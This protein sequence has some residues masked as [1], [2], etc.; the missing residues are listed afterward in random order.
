MPKISWLP[1]IRVVEEYSNKELTVNRQSTSLAAYLRGP[2]RSIILGLAAILLV[3]HQ[4]FAATLPSGFSETRIAAGLTDPTAMAFAPDGRLFVCLQ[5]GQLRLIKDGA[6]LDQPFLTVTVDATGERGLLGVAFDPG[7]A[8]NNFIY[9]YYTVAST[10]RHNRVSRFTAAGDTTVPGSETVILELE[11]LSTATNHNGG[12]LHF[13]PDDRLYVAVGENADGQNAQTLSNRLGKL[14][15][16]NADGTIPSDN[17]FFNQA[18]GDNR[19]IWALG[20][21]NPFTF[22]FQSGTG[23]LFINDVGANAWEEINDGNAGAN[24]GWPD[25]EGPTTDTRYLSPI[26]AYQTGSGQ[27]PACAISGGTFYNPPLDQFPMEFIGQYFFADFC[28]GWIRQLDPANPATAPFFA[29]D[30]ALPVDLQVG[31]DG[32]LYYLARG[33]GGAVFQ[34]QFTGRDPTSLQFSAAAY[35]VSENAG[36]ATITVTRDGSASGAVAVDFATSDGSAVAGSDYTPTSGTLS[37]ADGD[38]T[39]KNFTV[40]ITN[41]N[42]AEPEE[43]VNLALSNPTG[44]A[45]LGPPSSSATLNIVNED[46]GMTSGGGGCVLNTDATPGSMLPALVFSAFYFLRRKRKAG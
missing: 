12:A 1:R 25:T 11:D 32:S 6:L 3:Y 34:V 18:T 31:P 5:G 19:A 39:A 22:A 28:G 27:P 23:R 38:T 36:N 10:P 40:P 43:T 41:D 2:V 26:F 13:G 21:R 9:I 44:G 35:R 7:F 42:A 29:R 15:R 20:L 45:S 46:G 4:S 8:V 30:I 16:I 24:Y 37:F 33:D 14:L 17:P